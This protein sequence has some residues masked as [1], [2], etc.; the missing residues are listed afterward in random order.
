MTVPKD[1]YGMLSKKKSNEVTVSTKP[2]KAKPK[3]VKHHHKAKPAQVQHKAQ[4]PQINLSDFT[5]STS[6]DVNRIKITVNYR[7]RAVQIFTL[8]AAEYA[9]WQRSNLEQKYTYFMHQTNV[10]GFGN[11]EN[12]IQSVIFQ[13]IQIIDS[14]FAQAAAQQAQRLFKKRRGT[15]MV[16]SETPVLIVPRVKCLDKNIIK[17]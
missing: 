9:S 4:Q 10:R 2:T 12:I 5:L 17:T 15:G 6:A 3:T 8:S 7:G 13:T 14:A 1:I 11:D 16:C